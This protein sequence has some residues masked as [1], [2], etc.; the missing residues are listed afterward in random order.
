M[1]RDKGQ[2]NYPEFIGE[3]SVAVGDRPN[4]NDAPLTTAVGAFV[5][6][7]ENNNAS[8]IPENVTLKIG[9]NENGTK[10][11][12]DGLLEKAK[13]FNKIKRLEP[14]IVNTLDE[15]VQESTNFFSH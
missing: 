1:L 5:S 15:V 6:V 3:K 12:L 11:L 7:C 2:P 8:Y 9:H 13:G 10:Q 4:H 14:V